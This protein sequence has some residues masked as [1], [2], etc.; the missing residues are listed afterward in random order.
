MVHITKRAAA[1]IVAA[2]LGAASPAFSQESSGEVL[3]QLEKKETIP[4]L[5]EPAPPRNPTTKRVRASGSQR[6]RK[7]WPENTG[8]GIQ[9][10]RRNPS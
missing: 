4:Q 9:N 10:T 2:F 6:V 5:L 7:L 3:K 1:L 8:Q